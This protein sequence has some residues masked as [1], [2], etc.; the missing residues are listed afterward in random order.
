[1]YDIPKL[2]SIDKYM[3]CIEEQPKYLKKD[4]VMKY[5]E[6]VSDFNIKEEVE[7]IKQKGMEGLE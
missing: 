4:K 3:N 2:D 1:M 5:I 7:I 6:K